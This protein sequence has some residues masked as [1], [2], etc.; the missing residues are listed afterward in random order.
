[1]GLTR[2]TITSKVADRS[3]PSD[4]ADEFTGRNTLDF[5]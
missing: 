1:M 2:T 3:P 4:G 5:L